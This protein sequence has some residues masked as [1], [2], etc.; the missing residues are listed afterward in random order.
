M[1]ILALFITSVYYVI[2]SAWKFF[3]M[4]TGL[5]GDGVAGMIGSWTLVFIVYVI[6]MMW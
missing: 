6:L 3:L 2:T 5:G 4:L 1:W